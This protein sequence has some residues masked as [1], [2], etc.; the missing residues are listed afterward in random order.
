M[1]PYQPAIQTTI[2]GQAVSL[3]YIPVNDM[4]QFWAFIKSRKIHVFRLKKVISKKTHPSKVCTQ[5]CHL[6]TL[7][8]LHSSMILSKGAQQECSYI[9]LMLITTPLIEQAIKGAVIISFRNISTVQ[10]LCNMFR[11]FRGYS[12]VALFFTLCHQ[13]FKLVTISNS[14]Q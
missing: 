3:G 1:I 9:Q 11:L 14:F 13:L 2:Y 4:K 8:N 6:I 5:S 7:C 12:C 10:L